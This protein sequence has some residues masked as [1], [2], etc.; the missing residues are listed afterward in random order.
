MPEATCSIANSVPIRSCAQILAAHL[1]YCLA[2]C[3]PALPDAPEGRYT[4]LGCD[5]VSVARGIAM[6]GGASLQRTEVAEW[7][8]LVHAT[9]AATAAAAA[10][11]AGAAAPGVNPVAAAADAVHA[12]MAALLPYKLLYAWELA[13]YGRVAEA[14]SYCAAVEAGIRLGAAVAGGPPNPAAAA[15]AA[16]AARL[17]SGVWL[18]STEAQLRRLQDRLVTFAQANS[19][20]LQQRNE[21]A[22]TKVGRFLDGTLNKLL[23]GGETTATAGADAAAP[24][25]G[26]AASGA[27]GAPPPGSALGPQTA[28][29]GD[30]VPSVP[31][32]PIGPWHVDQML[33]L[34]GQPPALPSAP[35]GQGFGAQP[36][37][38]QQA[39]WQVAAAAA[40][41]PGAAP[42]APA[43]A[44]GYGAAPVQQPPQQQPGFVSPAVATA[45]SPAYA[46][47]AAAAPAA[48]STTALGS[49]PYS[50][51]SPAVGFPAGAP[52]AL[53]MAPHGQPPLPAVASPSYQQ[54]SAAQPFSQAP[55][56]GAGNS[57]APNWYENNNGNA[58]AAAAQPSG[59]P[60]GAGQL[61]GNVP[62]APRSVPGGTATGSMLPGY[63]SGD[64]GD[65]FTYAGQ[66]APGAPA[67]GGYGGWGPAQGGQ[68]AYIQSEYGAAGGQ[69]GGPHHRRYASAVELPQGQELLA[70]PGAQPGQGPSSSGGAAGGG[71]GA[72]DGGRDKDDSK[73]HQDT[74]KG[75]SRS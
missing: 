12:Q 5:F 73:K 72:K 39:A 58:P 70:P 35:A 37:Q 38:P 56:S 65:R 63:P 7:V 75:G 62:S 21:S 4:L 19:I 18:M 22:I 31:L 23:W 13:E 47:T 67:A 29:G 34:G 44:P 57:P 66:A 32:G 20:S 3:P 64:F 10:G 61:Y 33:Q 15:A 25:A 24:A 54:A 17:P 48:A 40:A 30:S 45:A 26:G 69:Q 59:A 55:H 36:L 51:Y 68:M 43:P 49:S 27:A 50:N 46:S 60:Y 42:F 1:C 8:A 52:S 28:V 53:G 41:A 16:A 11:A 14:L 6:D 71:D 74:K 2:S 9:T